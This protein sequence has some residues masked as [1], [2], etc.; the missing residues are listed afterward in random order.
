M[1]IVICSENSKECISFRIIY[2][3][4]VRIQFYVVS[5]YEDNALFSLLW[6][7]RFQR[8]NENDVQCL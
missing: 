8:Y 3:L 4:K 1:F 7:W 6:M 5:F 2:F